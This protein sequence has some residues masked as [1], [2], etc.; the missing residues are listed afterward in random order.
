MRV[1]SVH[2]AQRDRRGGATDGGQDPCPLACAA[3]QESEGSCFMWK[4]E[5]R[6]VTGRP[7]G[8]GLV[9]GTRA[10]V[11]GQQRTHSKCPSGCQGLLTSGARPFESVVDG[12]HGYVSQTL[13]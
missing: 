6:T 1:G 8:L 3:P 2:E 5:V 7:N 12:I 4:M 13:V 10:S 11:R 9:V